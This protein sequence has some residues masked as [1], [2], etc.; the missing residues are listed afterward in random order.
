MCLQTALPA[1]VAVRAA[2]PRSGPMSAEIQGAD[3]TQQQGKHRG[4]VPEYPR[5]FHP[6]SLT[7]SLVS[8]SAN[9][10][11]V[12]QLAKLRKRIKLF[13]VENMQANLRFAIMRQYGERVTMQFVSQSTGWAD[14]IILAMAPL[15]IIT[16]IVGAIRVGSPP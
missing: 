10:A 16:L 12:A 9:S 2:R 1:G 8:S 15:G 14:C 11:K 3:G 4:V 6:L 7:I 5:T 13:N